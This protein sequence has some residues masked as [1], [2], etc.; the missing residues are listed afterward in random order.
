MKYEVAL[1]VDGSCRRK[2]NTDSTGIM[3][4]G[5][6]AVCVG[7]GKT[8]EYT[9]ELGEGTNNIAELLAI[10]EGLL[11]I[12]KNRKETS[13]TV[14]SDSEYAILAIQNTWWKIKKN[15]E[16]IVRIRALCGEFGEV[17]FQKVKGH[18]GHQGNDSADKL[19]RTGSARA[20]NGN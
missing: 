10:E 4:A 8:K 7:N 20:R 13:V 15:K 18:S 11:R 12:V 19:A 5:I 1:Y 17:S 9:L 16:L 14:Y 3:G 2:K 6:R